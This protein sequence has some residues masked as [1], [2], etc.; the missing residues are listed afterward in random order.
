M[1]FLVSVVYH[2]IDGCLQLI[3]YSDHSPIEYEENEGRFNLKTI[4]A[5][6]RMKMKH[7]LSGVVVAS[8]NASGTDPS[9]SGMSLA[10]IQDKYNSNVSDDDGVQLFRKSRKFYD[11]R[12]HR[13]VYARLTQFLA[14]CGLF[15][16]K[17]EPQ[18]QHNVDDVLGY[19]PFVTNSTWGLESMYCRNRKRRFVAVVDGESAMT[20]EQGL[21]SSICYFIGMVLTLFSFVAFM[22]WMDLPAGAIGVLCAFYAIFCIRSVMHTVKL[23]GM[24]DNLRV[25]TSNGDES[26]VLYQV[27]ETFRITEPTDTLCWMVL[28]LELIFLFVIPVGALYHSG[29]VPVSTL[30]IFT[31]IVTFARRYCN[32]TIAVQEFG[33]LDGIEKDNTYYSSKKSDDPKEVKRQ[34]DE[35]WRE[36][37]RLGYILTNISSGNRVNFWMS[38]FTFF[39]I[40]FCGV[41]MTALIKGSDAGSLEGGTYT[42]ALQYPG[43]NNLEYASCMLG[44]EITPP[45]ST[46]NSLAD[47][48]FLTKIA[49][50]DPGVAQESLDAWFGAGTATVENNTVAEFKT[51]YELENGKS[52]V[53]YKLFN[54]PGSDVGIVSIRG[55]S[56][57]WDALSDAQLWSAAALAQWV[58]ALMPLGTWFNPILTHLVNLV[59]S[60]ES[61]HLAKVAFYRQT[62][63]FVED[64]KEK[65]EYGNLLVTGHSLGGGLA[66]IT[67]AQTKVP[68]IAL[69]GPNAVISGSTFDPPVSLKD[70]EKYTFNIVPDRDVVP[71]LDDLSQNYQRINCRTGLNDPISCHFGIRSLC[72]VLLSCGSHGRPVPCACLGM[73]DIYTDQLELTNIN[74]GLTLEQTIQQECPANAS[75]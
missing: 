30:F 45:D 23:K 20:R 62:A 67:G 18:R 72:E 66:M 33:S 19:A 40:A 57:G 21:S 39:I 25:D 34:K 3:R 22:V 10:E 71:R 36:K 53:E 65:N 43:S 47:F 68:A 75:A 14:C 58:R 69:S 6:F 9:S 63:A 13:S 51:D 29:N 42:E 46:E 38:V 17:E 8:Y 1:V 61:E 55:T 35:E 2:E 48:T 56:N 31:S 28:F 52:A 26:E 49:Y 70:L 32:S 24:Y 5:A 50:E 64:L 44:R 27:H 54:F 16:K 7:K 60:I 37:H 12:E 73:E 11:Y 59:S 41:F 4:V 74:S 15:E